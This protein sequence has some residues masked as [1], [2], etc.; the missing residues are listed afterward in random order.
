MSVSDEVLNVNDIFIRSVKTLKEFPKYKHLLFSTGLEDNMDY[1]M[2]DDSSFSIDSNMAEFT[3]DALRLA[4]MYYLHNNS[5]INFDTQLLTLEQNLFSFDSGIYHPQLIESIKK[6]IEN[7]EQFIFPF[8]P[9]T[10]S[11]HWYTLFIQPMAR[12][13]IIINPLSKPD[14]KDQYYFHK[15]MFML[16][17]KLGV[18][19][20]ICFEFANIQTSDRSCGESTLLIFLAILTA[21]DN[22]YM[23]LIKHLHKDSHI[24]SIND[25]KQIALGQFCKC[26]FCI[27]TNLPFRELKQYYNC[28]K[29]CKELNY[30]T[31]VTKC[32]Y[33]SNEFNNGTCKTIYYTTTENRKN[34]ERNIRQ[35]ILDIVE[36]GELTICKKQTV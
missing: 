36:T 32:I 11:S 26:K 4:V 23:N 30:V 31:N 17:E 13:I 12:R 1:D 19:Y 3:S 27:G 24:D 21:G 35:E 22:G 15:I 8:L 9:I 29:N 28:C 2:N 34:V 18:E 7:G 16:C 33:C 10:G 14:K 20:R 25:I 6:S 5:E